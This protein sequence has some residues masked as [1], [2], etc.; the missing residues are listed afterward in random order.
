MSVEALYPLQ[1]LT[2]Q[3]TPGRL[4]LV[5]EPVEVTNTSIIRHSLSVRGRAAGYTIEFPEDYDD[6]LAAVLVV[7]G[8]G[9]L[10][11]FYEPLRHAIATTTQRPAITMPPPRSNMTEFAHDI[12]HPS[13]EG[14]LQSAGLIA[15]MESV[16]QVYG[17]GSYSVACHSLGGQ[18]TGE[19]IRTSYRSGHTLPV[20]ENVTFIASSGADGSSLA[21][22]ARRAPE[23]FMGEM[24]RNMPGFAQ[25]HPNKWEFVRDARRY[26]GNPIEVAC[27]GIATSNY[28]LRPDAQTMR[29]SHI[30]TAALTP[31]HDTLFSSRRARERLGQIVDICMEID[32]DHNVPLTKPAAVTAALQSVWTKLKDTAH[33]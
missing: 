31:I 19:A 13:H 1:T 25:S 27:E 8:W 32:G 3:P 2:D 9:G 21:T 15:V 26:Y 12:R 20:V 23:F 18:T 10:E 14:S 17:L 30:G 29:A 33:S 7:P 4:R 22:L 28:D 6:R 16:E 11:R 24:R 5:P